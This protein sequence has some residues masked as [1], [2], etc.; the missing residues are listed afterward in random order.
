MSDDE[1]RG[2]AERR[3][4]QLN[5]EM[6]SLMDQISDLESNYDRS[7]SED[8]RLQDLKAREEGINQEISEVE[9]DL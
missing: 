1:R 6:A 8:Q 5:G 4:M 3:L 9:A 2:E 7:P